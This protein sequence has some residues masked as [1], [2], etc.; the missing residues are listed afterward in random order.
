MSAIPDEWA[1]DPDTA[2]EQSSGTPRAKGSNKRKKDEP[3][4]LVYA[5]V[6]DFVTD[7]LAPVIRRKLDGQTLTWCPRWW[8][9]PEAVVR[10]TALWRAW[11]H[12][13][14]DPA[15]GM[16]Q[17]FL[18]HCDPHLRELMNADTGPLAKC[19]VTDGHASVRPLPPLLIEKSDPAMWLDP[20]FSADTASTP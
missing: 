3:P 12:L 19:S 11:E 16:S 14:L 15:L 20:A 13:R 4:P 6:N 18:H 8:A 7:W 1:D 9:H 10:L 2:T 5:T 17:W